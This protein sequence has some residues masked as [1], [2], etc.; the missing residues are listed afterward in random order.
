VILRI[1]PVIQVE[2]PHMGGVRQYYILPLMII[3]LLS[4]RYRGF[5]VL[6]ELVRILQLF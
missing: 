4:S 5:M 1:I 6:F 3:Y 2:K